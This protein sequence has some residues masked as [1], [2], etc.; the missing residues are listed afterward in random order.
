MSLNSPTSSIAGHFE[1]TTNVLTVTE[2]ESF[3]GFLSGN[4][5]FNGY[6][7]ND[8]RDLQGAVVTIRRTGGYTGRVVVDYVIRDNTARAGF[9]YG[10]VTNSTAVPVA[11]R[12][13]FDD[14]QMSTNF[15]VPILPALLSGLGNNSVSFNTNDTFFSIYITNVLA[16]PNPVNG[17]LEATNL[18]PTFSTTPKL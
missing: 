1:F 14:W 18:Q 9:E 3:P 15:V 6:N 12:I 16:D 13:T 8:T 7:G 2:A 5:N 11:G 4:G 17:Y 10:T